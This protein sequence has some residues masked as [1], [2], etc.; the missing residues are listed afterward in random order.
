MIDELRK[1]GFSG[2]V[3][4]NFLTK[5]KTSYRIGGFAPYFISPTSIDDLRVL[6]QLF[7]Q[8]PFKFM[9][10]GKGSN[11]LFGDGTL[12]TS[13][14]SLENIPEVFEVSND[15]LNVSSNVSLQKII[16]H[17]RETGAQGF[18]R[19][20]GIPG[21]V[22]GSIKMNAGTHLG[23]ISD[24]LKSFRVFNFRTGE[25]KTYSKEQFKFSY[26]HN[27]LLQEDDVVLSAVLELQQ[28]DLE[29]VKKLLDE[30][31]KRRKETQPL[32]RPNCGSVFRNPHGEKAWDLIEKVG[33]KGHRIGDAQVSP[34][35]SNWIVNLGNAT[36]N[37]VKELIKLIQNK[38]YHQFHIELHTEVQYVD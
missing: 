12:T 35:H 34:M 9:V 26:R 28:G 21:N 23:E 18:E 13:L 2:E 38:V 3:K 29:Q 16:R 1:L 7:R 36:S 17:A 37:D 15:Q 33:L 24:L 14:I 30:T 25:E 8:S 27:Y 22:G 10:L 31:L 5:T 4:E 11:V 6:S 19:L 20:S 32:D